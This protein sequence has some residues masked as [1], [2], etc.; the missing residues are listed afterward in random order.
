M[1]TIILLRHGE[2]AS[3]REGRIQGQADSI[4][5][6]KGT[7]QAFRYGLAIKGLI[8]GESGWKVVSSP[9]GRCAQTAGI[10][11]EAAGLD[12]DAVTF[13]PRLMEVNTGS[14]SGRLKSELPPEA[15]AG[16]GLDHWVFRSPDGE[17]HQAI[18]ARLASWLASLN[19]GEKII[20][21][22]HGIAGRVLR[23]IYLGLD[24]AEAMRSDSPQDALFM[25]R[26]GRMERMSCA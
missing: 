7:E 26:A 4:L 22:S 3:N 25:L 5:T 20:C 8:A 13:D 1:P 17:S 23:G 2:T 6:V 11:C 19:P 18:T 15:V 21:I 16:T 9:L 12:A 14:L 24:P 10:L